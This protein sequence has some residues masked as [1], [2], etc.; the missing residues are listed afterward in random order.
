M[1]DTLV[2][3]EA[4]RLTARLIRL[5]A[6]L[7]IPMRLH[8]ECGVAESVGP[9]CIIGDSLV[10]KTT[11]LSALVEPCLAQYL[12]DIRVRTIEVHW[13]PD[14]YAAVTS[15]G[16]RTEF[17]SVQDLGAALLAQ[18]P[19]R[20]G[21]DADE[22][23]N[24]S[25]SLVLEG[26]FAALKPTVMRTRPLAVVEVSP[27]QSDDDPTRARNKELCDSASGIIVCLTNGTWSSGELSVIASTLKNSARPAWIAVALGQM[28]RISGP[29]DIKSREPQL[30]STLT[31]SLI[32]LGVEKTTAAAFSSSVPIIALCALANIERH[33][34]ASYANDRE[35]DAAALRG[36]FYPDAT[37]DGSARLLDLLAA[38]ADE[39]YARNRRTTRQCRDLLK[40]CQAVVTQC[41]ASIERATTN[42]LHAEQRTVRLQTE[43]DGALRDVSPFLPATPDS[44]ALS[45]A[46]AASAE[47]ALQ[48]RSTTFWRQTGTVD[49]DGIWSAERLNAAV[50]EDLASAVLESDVA[51]AL[52]TLVG[53]AATQAA[54]AAWDVLLVT[55]QLPVKLGLGANIDAEARI[56][57]FRATTATWEEEC[58]AST[59]DAIIDALTIVLT[60]WAGSTM[61]S[62][63][64]Q[65]TSELRGLLTEKVFPLPKIVNL[66]MEAHCT[67]LG[68]LVSQVASS[69][70]DELAAGLH[71]EAL[72]TTAPSVSVGELEALLKESESL[73]QEALRLTAPVLSRGPLP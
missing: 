47:L 65:V 63:V 23:G 10:G 26:P 33:V 71:L 28:D 30:R 44:S 51:S 62:S 31:Q 37:S 61:A 55:R 15:M 16:I 54:D 36:R 43:L 42:R 50:L 49:R 58:F 6:K 19:K 8:A 70:G 14:S 38:A 73:Q 66:A 7:G 45:R 52:R 25:V 11:L 17:N 60:G 67:Q 46:L 41:R 57:Q 21:E 12:C 18:L 32:G 34:N 20:Q 35:R 9:V 2:L 59:L 13:K 48:H 5:A 53:N 3:T 68:R 22:A 4:E 1:T 40:D 69:V 39:G 72:G 64:E 29:R 56:A 24:S 27:A